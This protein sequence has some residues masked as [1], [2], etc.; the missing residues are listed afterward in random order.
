MPA[1]GRLEEFKDKSNLGYTVNFT[2]DWGPYRTSKKKKEFKK[3][4]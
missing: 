1:L 3:K 2:P 4:D